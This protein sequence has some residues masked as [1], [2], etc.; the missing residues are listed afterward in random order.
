MLT[1]SPATL[2]LSRCDLPR[3]QTASGAETLLSGFAGGVV[4]HP[5]PIHLG[6]PTEAARAPAGDGCVS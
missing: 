1:G 5:D 4:K 2:Q 6:H 3:S